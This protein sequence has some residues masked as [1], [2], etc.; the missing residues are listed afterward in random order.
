MWVCPREQKR[1]SSE[2]SWEG[3]FPLGLVSC[4]EQVL[5]SWKRPEMNC[6]MSLLRRVIIRGY[7]ELASIH[8]RPKMSWNSPL[9]RMFAQKQ[10]KERMK[11]KGNSLSASPGGIKVI[12]QPYQSSKCFSDSYLFSLS[13]L[14]LWRSQRLQSEM[15]AK[16][17]YIA[18]E[19]GVLILAHT[20][21]FFSNFEIILDVQKS[22]RNSTKISHIIFTQLSFVLASYITRV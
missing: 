22:Y 9:R 13:Q 19:I 17:F 2:P 4:Q 18:W 7:L 10:V 6:Q 3:G 1:A 21:F 14:Q 11:K 20:R 12:S 8:A 15:G 16:R 5:I